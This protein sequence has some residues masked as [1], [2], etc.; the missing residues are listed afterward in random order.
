MMHQIAVGHVQRRHCHLPGLCPS[1]QLGCAAVPAALQELAVDFII[2]AGYL[3][4]VPASL[5]RAYHRAVLNIHPALL[6]SFGGAGF[7][8]RRV[9]EAVIAS[10]ARYSGATVHFIDEEYDTGP[11]LAQ[12]AVQVSPLDTPQ[13]LAAKVLEWEHVLYPDCV[14]AL[15]EGRITWRYDGVPIVW[16]AE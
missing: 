16:S 11:I 10:G 9:H 5:V 8:G 14:A 13:R 2:L 6:P 15:C 3:K 4:L 12:A 1:L 7:Y